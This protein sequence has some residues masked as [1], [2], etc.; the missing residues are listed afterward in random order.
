[1]LLE[2]HKFGMWLLPD[3]LP[4]QR[5]GVSD[6][7]K[8]ENFCGQGGLLC[9]G[10]TS[11]CVFFGYHPQSEWSECFW[12]D[13]WLSCFRRSS[14]AHALS[15][16]SR[17][18]CNSATAFVATAPPSCAV[19]L[20]TTESVTKIAMTNWILRGMF[21]GS[22]FTPKSCSASGT[23]QTKVSMVSPLRSWQ[24]RWRFSLGF[25]GEEIFHLVEN[26]L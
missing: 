15:C 16:R 1:M 12:R 6:T 25:R 14:L 11:D 7:G 19:T 2:P 8:D 23:P 22:L 20:P 18:A 5:S 9:E 4:V 21:W 24:S 13:W 17:S 3:G 10:L 26:G